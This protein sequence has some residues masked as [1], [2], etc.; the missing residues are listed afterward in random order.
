MT[1]L[2]LMTLEEVQVLKRRF[3]DSSQTDLVL[4]KAEFDRMVATMMWLNER[5][6]PAPGIATAGILGK[7]DAIYRRAGNKP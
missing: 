6:A 5:D 4:T 3:A 2:A 7:A 1:E